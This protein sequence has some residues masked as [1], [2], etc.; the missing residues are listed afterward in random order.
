L[1]LF[2][3]PQG[4]GTRLANLV[5]D[6]PQLS[7]LAILQVSGTGTLVPPATATVVEFYNA[8]LDHYFISSLQADIQALD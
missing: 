7:D 1:A 5:I 3:A 2:F 6:S 4:I 8:A